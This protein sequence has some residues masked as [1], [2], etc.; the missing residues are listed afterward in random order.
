MSHELARKRMDTV[1]LSAKTV[2][3]KIM[4]KITFEELLFQ[5]GSPMS[6]KPA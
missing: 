3:Q 1:K 2:D 5:H 6:Y 4:T